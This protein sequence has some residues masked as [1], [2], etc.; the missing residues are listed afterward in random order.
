M[1]CSRKKK[2]NKQAFLKHFSCF[3]YYHHIKICSVFE[4]IEELKAKRLKN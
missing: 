3:G 4:A 1:H 2:Q